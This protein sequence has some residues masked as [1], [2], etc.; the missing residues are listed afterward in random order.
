MITLFRTIRVRVTTRERCEGIKTRGSGFSPGLRAS[1]AAQC[2]DGGTTEP[3]RM[4]PVPLKLR[5]IHDARLLI[6]VAATRSSW[7]SCPYSTCKNG[8][9]H[10]N[11]AQSLEQRQG[12]W[13]VCCAS[14]NHLFPHLSPFR[15]F[16]L[17]VRVYSSKTTR[18]DTHRIWRV[19]K[20]WNRPEQSSTDRASSHTT[21]TKTWMAIR[22]RPPSGYSVL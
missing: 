3:L 21:K 12:R 11:V 2:P 20:R 8:K 16:P 15:F 1:A 10:D 19:P 17:V 9:S 5:N 13:E 22:S 14:R 7:P 4:Y 6:S 18:S